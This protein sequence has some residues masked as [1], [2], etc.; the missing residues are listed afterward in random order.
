MNGSKLS[1]SSSQTGALGCGCGA[2]CFFRSEYQKRESNVSA[3]SGTVCAPLG[4]VHDLALRLPA[5]LPVGG[6]SRLECPAARPSTFY[7]DKMHWRPTAIPSSHSLH[8]WCDTLSARGSV[9][10]I[11]VQIGG[12]AVD[13]HKSQEQLKQH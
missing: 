4:E 10:G 3:V 13:A 8:R 2:H 11:H 6:F 7:K 1:T 5:A 12:A 9:L